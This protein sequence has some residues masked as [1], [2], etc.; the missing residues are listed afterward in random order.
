[1]TPHGGTIMETAS[2]SAPFAHL[3]ELTV[4]LFAYNEE[5]DIEAAVR[6]AID[7][8]KGYPNPH[9]ILVI[10]DGSRDRTAE[11]LER[12]AAEEPVVRVVRH[13][14]NLGIFRTIRDLYRHARYEWIFVNST[15]RQ[16]SMDELS[17]LAGAAPA[18]D[19]VVGQRRKKHYT[20]YRHLISWSYNLSARL[21]FGVQTHDAGSIKLVRKSVALGLPVSSKGVYGEAE[22]LIRA[23]RSGFHVGAVPVEHRPRLNGK[24]RGARLPVVA[25]AIADVAAV[26][27][28]LVRHGPTRPPAATA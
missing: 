22:M 27:W 13:P 14:Q 9:E 24:A 12:I 25:R 23:S 11:I 5:A 19:I 2:R 17:N 15:D 26:W 8:V 3:P 6:D 16:W 21:L 20:P 18:S 7:L 1:M 4:G 10:E 28:D